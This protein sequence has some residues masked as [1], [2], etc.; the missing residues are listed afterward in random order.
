MTRSALGAEELRDYF[1]S[2]AQA[3]D[4]NRSIRLKTPVERSPQNCSTASSRNT[5][6]TARR[7]RNT[8][9]TKAEERGSH[10]PACPTA[11]D[12]IE[13]GETVVSPFGACQRERACHPGTLWITIAG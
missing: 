9:I 2:Y 7:C 3:S 11:H 8:S 5:W 1:R 13:H 10:P 12:H 6:K 4:L